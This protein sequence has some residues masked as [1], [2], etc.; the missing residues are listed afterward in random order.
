MQQLEKRNTYTP[1]DASQVR[2]NCDPLLNREETLSVMDLKTSSNSPEVNLPAHNRGLQPLIYVKNL[3]NEPLMPCTACKA[4]KLLKTGKAVVVKFKPYTIKLNFECEN[5]TQEVILGVDSGSKF[6]GFSAV[7]VDTELICGTLTLDNRTSER[8]KEKK[9][10]RLSRRNKLWHRKSRFLNRK[11]KEGWLPPSIQRK[12]DTHLN[13]I[14][15]IKTLIPVN[16]VI[17]EV[18]NFDIQKIE[19][20]EIFGSEYQQGDMFGY[21]NIRSFLMFREKGLCQLCGKEFTKGNSSHIHHCKQRKDSGS[22]SVKNLALL[23]KKCHINLHKKGLKL[24]APKSYRDSTFMNIM[25]NRFI[26]DIP[27]VELT[28]GYITFTNRVALN[29][30]KTHYNDAFVITQGNKQKRIKPTEITQKRINNRK[31][32]IQKKGK[33]PS[34]RKQRYPIRPKDLL[35]VNGKIYSSM[36]SQNKGTAVRVSIL[37]KVLPLKNIEKVYH[38]GSLIIN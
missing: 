17:I 28:F 22:N 14:N 3:N 30:E 27:D 20:P 16:K 19:N 13:L 32:Q 5:K 23:H 34:I 15:R 21:Q 10:Y 11:R 38:F 36:G 25:K 9:A 37:N 33:L 31:L 6:I 1:T 35:W 4:K 26:K 24:K 29:I 18:G 8:M 12:Y 7:S 2:S